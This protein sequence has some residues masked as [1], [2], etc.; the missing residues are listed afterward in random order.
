MTIKDSVLNCPVPIQ[1]V[2][3]E[4]LELLDEFKKLPI[5]KD[6]LEIGTY[7]GGSLWYWINYSDDDANII[8]IDVQMSQED[9]ALWNSW[10]RLNQKLNLLEFNTIEIKLPDN[11]YYD[12]I[13]IDGDHRYEFA[14]H[15]FSTYYPKIRDGGFIALH[16][17][18]NVGYPAFG[19]MKLWYEIKKAG[20]NTKEII[21]LGE[22]VGGIGIVYKGLA[23]R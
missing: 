4:F 19:V 22:N 23:S 13:F 21:K 16:D 7:H 1:Q 12:F 18:H 11:N 3:V 2:D 20:Y 14:K 5:K 17:I 6:I 15:D 9:K 10:L 8:G